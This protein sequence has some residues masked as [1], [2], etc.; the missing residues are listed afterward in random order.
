[1]REHRT[2]RVSDVG[3]TGLKKGQ[4]NRPI[5]SSIGFVRLDRSGVDDSTN[6]RE[7]GNERNRNEKTH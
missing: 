3:P 4:A 2:G 5:N 1:M 6:R 7:I